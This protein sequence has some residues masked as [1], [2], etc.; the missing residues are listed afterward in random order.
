VLPSS[1]RV[2]IEPIDLQGTEGR[3]LS[4]TASIGIALAERG[5][6][7]ELFRN[8]DFALYEAKSRGKNRSIMFESDMQTAISDRLALEL[9]R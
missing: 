5:S 2:L 4:I 3:T 1:P 6:A 8:A 7:D 9:D